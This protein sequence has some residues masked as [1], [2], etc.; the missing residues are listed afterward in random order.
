MK[1]IIYSLA[2]L[3]ITACSGVEGP[4]PSTSSTKSSS[5]GL[6]SDPSGNSA[7]AASQTDSASKV[8]P[9]T[10]GGLGTSD[11]GGAGDGIAWCAH[12]IAGRVIII[13]HDKAEADACANTANSQGFFQGC[14]G[15]N[16]F[17]LSVTQ[18]NKFA[19]KVGWKH[20]S[21]TAAGRCIRFNPAPPKNCFSN[22]ETLW[23]NK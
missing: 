16:S 2:L 4:A 13:T 19:A 9:P 3:T 10:T 23:L 22:T 1:N 17:V 11:G 14:D 5:I 8:T 15:P 20:K 21:V 7:S 12:G 18:C 6:S